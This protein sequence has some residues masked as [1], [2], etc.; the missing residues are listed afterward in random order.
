MLNGSGFLN[1]SYLGPVIKIKPSVE[2]FQN[3]PIR[4]L[5]FSVYS[6]TPNT[7]IVT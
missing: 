3:N 4:V 1:G 2:Q 6:K 5:H 7:S